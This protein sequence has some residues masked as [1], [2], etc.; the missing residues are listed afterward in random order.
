MHS[1]QKRCMQPETSRQS[2]TMPAV[3]LLCQGLGF[4]GIS[5]AVAPVHPPCLYMRRV[6]A[7]RSPQWELCKQHACT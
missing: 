6:F 3:S 2:F 5:D 7:H 1:E 4:A